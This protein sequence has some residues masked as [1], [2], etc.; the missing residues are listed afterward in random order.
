MQPGLHTNMFFFYI[1]EMKS[2]S[3]DKNHTILTLRNT[4][5][6]NDFVHRKVL[7]LILKSFPFIVPASIEIRIFQFYKSF[8]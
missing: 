2:D 6:L 8:V 3:K 1:Q 7:R 5:S 4:G